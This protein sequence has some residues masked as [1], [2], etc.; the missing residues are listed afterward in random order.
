MSLWMIKE[1][2]PSHDEVFTVQVTVDGKE[3]QNAVV[4]RKKAAE[5]MAAKSTMEELTQSSLS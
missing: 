4:K 2:G 1:R 5:Q 3:I